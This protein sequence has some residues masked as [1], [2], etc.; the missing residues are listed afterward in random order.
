M[1]GV[2]RWCEGASPLGRYLDVGRESGL[3][4]VAEL[5]MAAAHPHGTR[6]SP[7]RLA[8][9]PYISVQPPAAAFVLPDDD[10]LPGIRNLAV[11][12]LPSFAESHI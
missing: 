4:R 2:L 9:I 1:V 6:H 10:V 3:R 7:G 12:I 11:A 8:R 5:A